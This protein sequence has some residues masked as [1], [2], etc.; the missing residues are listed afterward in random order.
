MSRTNHEA[1]PTT[2]HFTVALDST[3][4]QTAQLKTE[5]TYT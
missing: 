2:E 5:L 3:R 4:R 1:S